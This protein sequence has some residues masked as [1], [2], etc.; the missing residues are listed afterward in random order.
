MGAG[1]SAEG[2]GHVYDALVIGAGVC[3]LYQVH[4]LL[5]LG[6]DVVAFDRNE[7][8]G[9]TWYRNRYPGC[10][11]DSE[12]Y[13][14]GYS[15]SEELLEEWDWSEEFAA[16]PETLS[17]LNYVADKF[18]LRRAIEFG[19]RVVRAVFDDEQNT[20]TVTLDD[21]RRFTGR[22]LLTAMGH[23]STPTTPNIEGI[24][25][26]GGPAIHTYHW[27][28]EGIELEGKRVGVIGTGA[29][30]VQV[31]QTI[32]ETVGELK[33]FQRRPNWCAPLGNKPIDA[34]RMEQIRESYDEIFARC[35]ETVGGFLHNPDPRETLEVPEAERRAF[36]E[37]LY[38]SS[39]FGIWLGNFRDT[40]LDEE[41]N[42]ELSDF[43]AE[44]IRARVDDPETAEKLIPKDHG[45]GMR[46]VPLETNYY[47]AYNRD[48]VELVDLQEAPIERVVPQGVQTTAGVV[49]LDV[50]IFA[51]GF[52]A[53]TGAF[54]QVEI[55]GSDGRK[56]ADKWDDGPR[57]AYGVA[58]A[59]FPNLFTLLGPQSG[60]VS[61]NFPRGIE[62]IVDWVTAFLEF[63]WDKG[64][65]RIE[66]DPPTEQEWV[67]HARDMASRVLLSRSKSWFTGYNSNLQ[68]SEEPRLMI[69][70]G[71]AVRYREWLQDEASAGYPGFVLT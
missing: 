49:E 18:D 26:F 57:T 58:T 4:K 9:G 36:W 34:E 17:Y 6:A 51:T 11:F 23:L 19:V 30:G 16:R 8:V 24:D 62:E 71:G 43:I 65:D 63:A 64:V 39:G 69:Y 29:T 45:F 13:T 31:I 40:L 44:K 35:H 15:F 5:E 3:G 42:R 66:V 68:R 53:I 32:A 59:G 54:D 1:Q 27:P 48:N 67:D 46:R 2:D 56:L 22:V 50:L 61:T 37:E 70:T 20:W 12:S 60:S 47:E 25:S 28:E 21:G 7:D 41:A 14:Y 55:V 52:D 10:R 33:V 38:E